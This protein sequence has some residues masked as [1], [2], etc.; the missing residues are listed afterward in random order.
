[1][2][3]GNRLGLGR[4]RPLGAFSP[5]DLAN[6]EL[7]LDSS[8]GVNAKAAASFAS[9]TSEDL[10]NSST[11]FDKGDEDFSFGGWMYMTSLASNNTLI[12]KYRTSSANRS[13]AFKVLTSGAI[14][15]SISSD[16]TTATELTN[17][18]T[19]VINTWYFLIGVY[20]SVNDLIKISVNGAAFETLGHA[21]GAYA[22]STAD[23]NIGSQDGANLMDGRVDGAFF[24]DKALTIAQVG[25]LYNGSNGIAYDNIT[26]DMAISLVDWWELNELSGNR[27]G[28]LGHTLTD[29][30][31][32][33]SALGKI[34]EPVTNGDSVYQW[35]DQ[36]GNS[37][38]G[39][40]ETF[41]DQPIFDSTTFLTFDGTSEYLNIDTVVDDLAAT[42]GT[43]AMWVRPV[44]AT[45]TGTQ[46]IM[47][48][49]DANANGFFTLNLNTTGKLA[50]NARENAVDKFFS[51]SDDVILTTNTWTHLVVVQDGTEVKLYADGVEKGLTFS[52]S[53]DKTFWFADTTLIDTGT[54]GAI[55]FLSTT[56]NF[57]EGDIQQVEITSSALTA[58]EVLALKNYNPPV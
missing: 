38:F 36:S 33:T 16:G 20:D 47:S 52:V 2:F 45:P 31:T 12:A 54:I 5:S 41:I 8:V 14:R 25:A 27:S 19:L 29:N 50:I 48:F 44:D 9:A 34:V 37:N 39:V 18:S 51:E 43:W 35:L 15:F 30:N 40:Q 17:G 24:Y 49:G 42:T 4:V 56:A 26:A 28:A 7:W 53:T 57:F 21:G 32:V 1:M 46:I 10:T 23:F 6:L 13:Y 55:R 11:D 22:S 3:L 58:A